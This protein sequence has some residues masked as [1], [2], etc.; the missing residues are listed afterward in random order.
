MNQ[1][2]LFIHFRHEG[3]VNPLRVRVLVAMN[4]SG[5]LVRATKEA[6]TAMND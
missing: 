6:Q 1:P 3:F 5:Q 2:G 4:F